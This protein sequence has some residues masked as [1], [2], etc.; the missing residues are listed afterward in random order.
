[1]CQRKMVHRRL[2]TI[3]LAI[4]ILFLTVEKII[5]PITGPIRNTSPSLVKKSYW[6]SYH[7]GRFP[8]PLNKMWTQLS[9]LPLNRG[10]LFKLFNVCRYSFGGRIHQRQ[11]KHKPKLKI[12]RMT[13]CWMFHRNLFALLVHRL[14]TLATPETEVKPSQSK[15]VQKAISTGFQFKLESPLRPNI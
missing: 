8:K 4:I 9:L 6:F 1:M 5:R 10:F 14:T 12:N 13:L 3:W 15:E 11:R 2:E 7:S